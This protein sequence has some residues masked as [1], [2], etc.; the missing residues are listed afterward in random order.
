MKF[1]YDIAATYHENFERGPQ[2]DLAP[3]IPATEPVD[4]L[5]QKVNSRL[6][7]A[8]GLLLNAKWIE[9]YAA[10][11]WDLLT[12]KTV[13]SS[14]VNVTRPL[15][16]SSLMRMKARDPFTQRTTCRVTQARSVPPCVS[17]CRR[18]RRSFGGMTLPEPRRP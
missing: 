3:A 11:G 7:I 16:G 4:F 12:Y 5:G 1:A 6:G 18:C 8:A 13:R 15:I 17:E 14:G 9:G 2:L 10:R